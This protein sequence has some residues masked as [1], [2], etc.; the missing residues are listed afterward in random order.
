[1]D[2][3]TSPG[4]A[5]QPDAPAPAPFTP[6]PDVSGQGG[7]GTSTWSWGG[8]F[9][10]PAFL[11]AIRKYMYLWVYVLMFI[12]LLNIFAL[13][14]MAVFL[15]IKGH[16]LVAQS[17]AFLNSDERNG[18]TRAMDH[19]GFIMFLVLLAGFLLWFAFFALFF[20]AM[21]N[22]FGGMH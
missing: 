16:E 1:M 3:H 19:A 22:S 20:G 15:G 10:G 2:E 18:F 11:I 8:F 17:P 7:A 13:L 5:P 9:F 12:P 21:Y 14:G 6:G 4:G